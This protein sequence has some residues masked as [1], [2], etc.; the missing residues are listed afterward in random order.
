MRYVKN[1]LIVK[2]NYPCVKNKDG[3]LVECKKVE[4]LMSN[5]ASFSST[6]FICFAC[7]YF[8]SFLLLRCCCAV[9][10]YVGNSSK[11]VNLV[12]DYALRIQSCPKAYDAKKGLQSLWTQLS[13]LESACLQAIRSLIVAGKPSFVGC[14]LFLIWVS[15]EL[16]WL[17]F[18]LSVPWTKLC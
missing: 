9:F 18:C 3:L 16:G 15:M 10:R 14:N 7:W 2:R 1:I 8:T 6:C 5:S 12:F 4:L 13:W 11:D 17:G